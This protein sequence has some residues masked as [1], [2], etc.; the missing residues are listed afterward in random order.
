[1]E[2]DTN[3]RLRAIRVRRFARF[4]PLGI[5]LFLRD[6]GYGK[7]YGPSSGS[8]RNRVPSPKQTIR[9]TYTSQLLGAWS[10]IWRDEGHT[11]TLQGAW[12]DPFTVVDVNAQ[13]YLVSAVRGFVAVDNVG[14][15]KYQIN[16]SSTAPNAIV[17]QGMPRRVGVGVQVS[18]F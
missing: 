18:R 1:M 15:T 6:G 10:A 4:A 11:T 17:S 9:A 3:Q 12:L 2:A 16:L 5:G 13:R 8:H 14:D 7:R